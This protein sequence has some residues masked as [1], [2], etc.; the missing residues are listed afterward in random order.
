MLQQQPRVSIGLPVYNG[1]KYLREAIDSVLAQTYKDFELIISDN[2]STDGT[3]ELCE[4]YVAHD[5]R[6]RLHRFESNQGAARNYNI[7][8]E[9]SSAH[10]FKWIA[11][12]DTIEPEFIERTVE[13][14]ER[15]PAVS[16][17]YPKTIC[18]DGDGAYVDE[19]DAI[20]T[21][22]PWSDDTATRFRQVMDEFE[23]NGG[24]SANVYA[25]ATMRSS[26]LKKTKLL[27]HHI[28]A[29]CN[30]I[31]DMAL[32]GR[33]VELPEHLMALR[34]HSGSSS[35]FEAAEWSPERIQSFFDPSVNSRWGIAFSKRRM[36]IE[37]VSNV[38]RSDLSPAAKASLSWSCLRPPLRRFRRKLDRQF[39]ERLRLAPY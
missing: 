10:Y 20:M 9:L 14:L 25:F 29:D 34:A 11:C 12:D 4:E 17:V 24:A 16:L 37:H 2:G 21:H 8:F 3:V 38:W 7:V 18:I 36:H 32:Q 5:P 1:I 23:Q 26:A 35:W 19:Y 39:V 30:M 15:D 33:F 13:V 22:G 6:V 27:G 28:A 31:T